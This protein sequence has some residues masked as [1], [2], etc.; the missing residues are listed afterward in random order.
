MF[1]NLNLKRRLN[2][3]AI[4]CFFTFSLLFLFSTPVTIQNINAEG[5]RTQTEVEY[6]IIP[7]T[8]APQ[9]IER[10]SDEGALPLF[11]GYM[12]R[13]I[14]IGSVMVAIA[15]VFYGG[16]LYILS[17]GNPEKRKHAI[18]WIRGAIQG[19]LIILFSHAILASIDS[20]FLIF[21]VSDLQEIDSP[22]RITIDDEIKDTYFQIPLGL[23]IE[24]L[25]TNEVARDRMYDVLDATYDAEDSARGIMMGVTNMTD[26]INHC[27]VGSSCGGNRALNTSGW[28]TLT[29]NSIA[30]IKVFRHPMGCW[31][32]EN[33]TRSDKSSEFPKPEMEKLDK[34]IFDHGLINLEEQKSLLNLNR[35]ELEEINKDRMPGASEEVKR[36]VREVTER[37]RNI[38]NYQERKD[39]FIDEAR[40]ITRIIYEIEEKY[41]EINNTPL[42]TELTRI[43]NFSNTRTGLPKWNKGVNDI[44]YIEQSDVRWRHFRYGWTTLEK[45]GSLLASATMALQSFGVEMTI[46]DALSFANQNSYQISPLGGTMFDFLE[47][48]IRDYG[49]NYDKS[50]N[51]N[52]SDINKITNW[53]ADKK[54][55]VVVEG[56]DLPWSLEENINHS[57]VLTG[58]NQQS[59]LFYINDPR[60]PFRNTIKINDVML[61]LPTNIGYVY[62]GEAYKCGSPVKHGDKEYKT[63]RIGNQCWMAENMDYDNGC[64]RNQLTPNRRDGCAYYIDG[65][66]SEIKEFGLLYQWDAAA[67]VCPEGWRLATD[68]DWRVLERE[69]GMED[70]TTTLVWRGIWRGVG[71][72][73]RKLKSTSGWTNSGG[74]SDDYGFSALPGGFWRPRVISEADELGNP[75]NFGFN[76]LREEGS[77]WASS[78]IDGGSHANMR[79]LHSSQAGI[80]R[81]ADTKDYAFSVRCT[82][83]IPTGRIDHRDPADFFDSDN[84][85]LDDENTCLQIG[86]AITERINTMEQYNEKFYNDLIVLHQSK[87]II[88]ENM[89]QLQRVMALKSLGVNH[90]IDYSQLLKQKL[91]YKISSRINTKSDIDFTVLHRFDKNPNT[92][93]SWNW[94]KWEDNTLYWTD[95]VVGTGDEKACIIATIENDPLNFYLKSPE[96]NDVIFDALIELTHREKQKGLQYSIQR[97]IATNNVEKEENNTTKSNI[98]HSIISFIKNII[99]ILN[100]EKAHASTSPETIE[101]C[102][103]KLGINIENITQEDVDRIYNECD[104]S[105]TR[106][107]GENPEDYLTC[108]M[109]I[110]VGEIFDVLWDNYNNILFGIDG[111]IAEGLKLL[112]LQK[113]FTNIASNC[114]CACIAGECAVN[115]NTDRVNDVYYR[116]IAAHRGKMRAITRYIHHHT[117]GF[118]WDPVINVCSRTNID[119]I[120]DLEEDICTDIDYFITKHELVTRKL[121]YSRSKFNQCLVRP[122]NIDDVMGWG[123][124][125]TRTYFGPI[126]EVYDAPRN[127][128]TIIGNI[129]QNTH[130]FN[131]FCCTDY[132]TY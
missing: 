103:N 8:T 40:K 124:I 36:K 96:M 101:E 14:L 83:D 107:P 5:Q 132:E 88:E 64:Y 131:W 34:A 22:D 90:I 68:T 57:V 45:Q 44:P 37:M 105:L 19:I 109:E 54:G 114:S 18:G 112:E 11:M 113:N 106:M 67:D 110:P 128:K 95:E 60:N 98:Y 38:I 30:N 108:G 66:G 130:E 116:E 122:E 4:F 27:K 3:I 93:H 76:G 1:L 117:N 97:N 82:L 31:W 16:F 33:V 26:I 49:F 53:L 120:S 52:I 129:V 118:F 21:N 39:N 71:D 121:N 99:A 123:R 73:G 78:L 17:Q 100:N 28:P 51:P 2:K 85:D 77:W 69:L 15:V 91:E 79:G 6:P 35:L 48:I 75:I 62:N 63:I 59:G 104:P 42:Q 119:I 9:E 87:R 32:E 80:K 58:V 20:R 50:T 74:G 10:D 65:S 102:I 25:A 92:P 55:P 13:I 23:L 7:G 86:P 43:T 84:L 94:Q 115:C 81:S 56:V 127:T 70:L 111:Y 12:F 29:F 47:H 41:P 126:V 72:V 24:D 89:H 46:F 61:N 125:G